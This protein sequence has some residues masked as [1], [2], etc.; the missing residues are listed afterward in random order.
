MFA[1]SQSRGRLESL[2]PT[3]DFLRFIAEAKKCPGA[4]S[5]TRHC[6]VCQSRSFLIGVHLFYSNHPLR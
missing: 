6:H 5:A 1:T 3:K 4:N 2:R